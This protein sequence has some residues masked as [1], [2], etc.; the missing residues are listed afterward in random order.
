MSYLRR[1]TRT[2]KWQQNMKVFQ[3]QRLPQWNSI[4][5][6]HV[7]YGMEWARA[8]QGYLGTRA[9]RHLG[10]QA[11]RHSATWIDTWGTPGTLFSRL[12]PRVVRVL[13]LTNFVFTW[14]S[15]IQM[16]GFVLGILCA[17]ACANKW[18]WNTVISLFYYSIITVLLQCCWNHKKWFLNELKVTS[19]RK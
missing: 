2:H 17:T 10:T 6:K 8:L 11:L 12:L 13:I 15:C 14:Q 3:I 1:L 4:I 7:N 5:S 16:K 18:N 19:A 9:L